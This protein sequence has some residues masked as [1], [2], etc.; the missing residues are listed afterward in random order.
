MKMCN[1]D[2]REV[3]QQR[4][5]LL[6]LASNSQLRSLLS[7]GEVC[8]G[9]AALYLRVHASS[10]LFWMKY[11]VDDCEGEHELTH[12]EVISNL[13]RQGTREIIKAPFCTGNDQGFVMIA[14]LWQGVPPG[15]GE[16]LV[17]R[18]GQ[19]VVYPNSSFSA[20]KDS[21]SE[22]SAGHVAG[23]RGDDDAEEESADTGG[24]HDRLS[25]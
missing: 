13:P 2:E 25:V 12:M 9:S 16:E 6:H 20:D 11:R 22:G 4:P 5:R 23:I 18:T 19:R 3:A 17:V 24:E 14:R 8:S 7:P 1:V 21:H 15:T 10:P